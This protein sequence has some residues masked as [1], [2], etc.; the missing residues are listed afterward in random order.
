MIRPARPDDIEAI[1]EEMRKEDEE[2]IKASGFATGRD[3][4]VDSYSRS[5]FCWTIERGGVPVGMFVEFVRGRA[6]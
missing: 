6:S 3:A 2:E 1:S 4:L 5:Q